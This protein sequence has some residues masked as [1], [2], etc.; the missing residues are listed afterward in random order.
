MAEILA[1]TRTERSLA[2]WRYSKFSDIVSFILAHS[3]SAAQ[4]EKM[5]QVL[6]AITCPATA[7][8]H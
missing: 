2:N 8:E 3:K 7:C 6:N 4:L 5:N 1:Q